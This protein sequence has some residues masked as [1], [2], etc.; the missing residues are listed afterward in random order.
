EI[1]GYLPFSRGIN[2]SLSG[3]M[4][5]KSQLMTFPVERMKELIDHHYELTQALVHKMTSRVREYTTALQQ[6]EKMMALGK[7]SAGLA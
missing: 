4:I 7:L 6:D 5:E 1:F 3:F 2:A